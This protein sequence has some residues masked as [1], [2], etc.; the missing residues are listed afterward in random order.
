MEWKRIKK[1]DE[2]STAESI[3]IIH[4]PFRWYFPRCKKKQ[5]IEELIV[6]QSPNGDNKRKVVFVRPM[7]EIVNYN[8]F[9][10][11]LIHSCVETEDILIICHSDPVITRQSLVP[12]DLPKE[13]QIQIK[14]AFKPSNKRGIS[15]LL[16]HICNQ[17]QQKLATDISGISYIPLIVITFLT[18]SKALHDLS[19]IVKIK[20]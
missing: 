12:V 16:I 1:L 7:N 10:Q 14:S 8:M 20:R 19:H 2:T 11:E 9:I 18:R 15:I 5:G 4:I 6:Q 17:K 13:T 3:W